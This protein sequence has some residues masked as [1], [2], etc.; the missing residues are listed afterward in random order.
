MHNCVNA[1]SKS[2]NNK[3]KTA[4]YRDHLH[5][6]HSYHIALEANKINIKIIFKFSN[7]IYSP[8]QVRKNSKQKIQ[9]LNYLKEFLLLTFLLTIAILI[10]NNLLILTV[11]HSI[12]C[13]VSNFE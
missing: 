12:Q 4:T 5:D 9:K 11:F 7:R 10:V 8:L 2:K 6:Q 13:Q 1:N 3:I